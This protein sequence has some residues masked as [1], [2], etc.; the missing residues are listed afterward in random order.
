MQNLKP[1]L[2]THKYFKSFKFLAVI[3]SFSLF[4]F[5]FVRPALAAVL[6]LEPASGQ[7]QPGQT[8]IVKIKIDTEEEYINA[9]EVNLSYDKEI[10]KAIDF[11]Q[12]ESIITFWLKSAEIDE[13]K[14]EISFSGGIPGGYCGK[15]PGDPGEGDILG[16][17]I[18]E[19]PKIL[20]QERITA[21]VRFLEDSQVLLNDGLGTKAKLTLRGAKFEISEKA[22][23][24]IDQWEKE[25]SEDKIPPELFEVLV[26]KDPQIF[27]GKYFI[28]FQTLDKQTG[29]DYYEVKEGKRS[30]RTAE[31][32]YLLED[33]TL[34][35]IIKVRAVDKAG[36]ERVAEHIPEITARLFPYWVIV[37]I[38]IG[39][40]IG[41]WVTKSIKRKT[42]NAK[43]Q[44]KI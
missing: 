21:E 34:G 11:S 18:F 20:V 7:Y 31:S 33:Q 38:L 29:I 3:F 28:I 14:G 32:P 27:E 22:E 10:L 19:A 30:W 26:L 2:K 15:I 35:S 4:A 25:I 9:I 6:Y 1:Q 13:E 40:G 44:F 17:I 39:L 23:A 8:F 24:I 36:N 41:Y 5:S 43:Q 37:L 16:K 12:G 42:K